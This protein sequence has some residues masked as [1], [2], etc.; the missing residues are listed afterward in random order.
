MTDEELKTREYSRRILT[1]RM[2]VLNR[3]PFFGLMLMHMKFSLNTELATAATDG[4]G[5]MF[6][7]K[8]LDFLSDSELD[9]ILMHE[10]LHVAL[11]HCLRGNNYDP[12]LF[13]V[14][15]DIVVNS[16]I[17]KSYNMDLSSITIRAFG[18]SMHLAPNGK[19]GYLYT[20]EQVYEMMQKQ[21]NNKQKQGSG[22]GQDSSSGQGSD[23][24]QNSG[25]GQGSSSGQGSGSGSDN[26]GDDFLSNRSSNQ[27]KDKQ[28]NG[29]NDNNNSQNK[30]LSLP[31]TKDELT[32]RNGS[33]TVIDDHSVWGRSKTEGLS[34]VLS[35]HLAD[36]VAAL[37]IQDPS[38]KRGLVPLCA[39][40]F[41]DELTEPI[42]DWRVILANFID[43]EICDYSFAPPDKRYDSTGFF[44]PDYNEVEDKVE[45]ILFMIDTSGSVND[46]LVAKC[47][48]EIKGAIE[49]FDGH[50]SGKLGFFDAAVYEPVDFTS[51]EELLKIR[52]KGGG[53]TRFDI[54][55]D[56]VNKEMQDEPPKSIIILTDGY[57][58][59]PDESA[60]NG[61]PVLWALSTKDIE[62]PF[63]SVCYI[64]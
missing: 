53:G 18:E 55:F 47:Y 8:F 60:T 44:L 32:K 50:L 40:R 46:E 36:A 51:A 10:S 17:L 15:C 54:I 63:G 23:S 35:K 37:K 57:A 26:G 7:P 62:P 45:N 48:S 56:Y 12:H 14:A 59:F 3:H 16:N 34:D 43:E 33:H 6:A 13:N 24:G 38:N 21:D 29:N 39:E 11:Q 61:I 41:Y 42:N 58:P 9:F 19:E 22:S 4:D 20:A 25:S 31:D 27:G 49:Q 52:P 64:S 28:N 5:I 2:R 30:P 1:S